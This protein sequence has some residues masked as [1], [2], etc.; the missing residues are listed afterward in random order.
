MG[1][2]TS[3]KLLTKWDELIQDAKR[4]IEAA[5]QRIATLK[6]TVKSLEQVR[7]SGQEWPGR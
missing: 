2:N 3:G 7:D 1:R 5:K 6:K 4:Q